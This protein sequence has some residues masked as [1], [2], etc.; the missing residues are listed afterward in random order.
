MH[1]H[2]GDCAV[3]LLGLRI[4]LNSMFRQQSSGAGSS[5]GQDFNNRV[6]PEGAR[7]EQE[8]DVL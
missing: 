8:G 6:D 3:L 7:T 5:H 2:D 1:D 4:V